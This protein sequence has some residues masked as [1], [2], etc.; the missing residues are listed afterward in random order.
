MIGSFQDDRREDLVSMPT[1]RPSE[2]GSVIVTTQV[3]L[4]Q[5]LTLSSLVFGRAA[6]PPFGETG[7]IKV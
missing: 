2:L 1:G 3:S 4:A 6:D 5:L 7:H